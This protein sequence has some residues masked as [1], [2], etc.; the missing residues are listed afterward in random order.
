MIVEVCLRNLWNFALWWHILGF[1][2]PGVIDGLKSQVGKTQ[3]SLKFSSSSK[4]TSLD[5]LLMNP[6]P[7]CCFF[8]LILQMLLQDIFKLIIVSVVFRKGLT[9]Y[10][11]VPSV[12]ALGKWNV[13]VC[14][15]QCEATTRTL[16][17]PSQGST[18]SL[19]QRVRIGVRLE[20]IKMVR[21]M[22]GAGVWRVPGAMGTDGALRAQ[23]G[24]AK[25]TLTN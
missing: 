23:V 10:H 24:K 4:P 25:R 9:G 7:S 21:M 19:V 5:L 16:H 2:S 18:T 20:M 11:Q 1:V 8:L 17:R 22:R 12:C 15:Q 14:S 6:P 13:H 3:V